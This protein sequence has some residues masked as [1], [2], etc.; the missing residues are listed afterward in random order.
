MDTGATLSP[1]PS[2]S[3]FGKSLKDSVLPDKS[4]VIFSGLLMLGMYGRLVDEK[5]RF[6]MILASLKVV[7]KL[8]HMVG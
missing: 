3:W 8:P 6:S 4:T 2:K 1:K 5:R 7:L